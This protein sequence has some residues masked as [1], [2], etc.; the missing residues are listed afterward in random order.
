MYCVYIDLLGAVPSPVGLSLGLSLIL[1][2]S[3]GL[4]QLMGLSL[5]IS[6]ILGLSLILGFSLGLSQVLWGCP[7]PRT[8]PQSGGRQLRVRRV[9]RAAQWESMVTGRY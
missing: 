4:S 7:K 9:L 2:L 5:G 8:V 6:Q 3:L 1:G